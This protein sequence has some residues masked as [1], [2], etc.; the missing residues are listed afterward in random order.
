MVVVVFP[1][2]FVIV[3]PPEADRPV[4]AAMKPTADQRAPH[5]EPRPKMTITGQ[6][7]RLACAGTATVVVLPATRV[8]IFGAVPAAIVV[9]AATN[10]RA[11]PRAPQAVTRASIAMTGHVL[12][13]AWTGALTVTAFEPAW[14]VAA[15]TVEAVAWEGAATRPSPELRTPQAEPE[16]ATA[17][18]GQVATWTSAGAVT[19]VDVRLVPWVAPV[20]SV[21][22]DATVAL[23]GAVTRAPAAPVAPQLDPVLMRAAVGHDAACACVCAVSVVDDNPF[24]AEE[25]TVTEGAVARAAVVGAVAATPAVPCEPQA[26]PEATTATTGQEAT[27]ACVGACTLTEVELLP[28]L[29]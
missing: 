10:A 26:E 4:G 29:C 18:T 23:V 8:E 21:G 20:E 14:I 7:V 13:P 5:A 9:G 24:P 17:T 27:L 25:W 1:L 12:R 11:E 28:I 6:V 19:T 15:G 2:R 22:A 16:A 3:G